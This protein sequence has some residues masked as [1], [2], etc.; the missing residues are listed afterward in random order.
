MNALKKVEY[1]FDVYSSEK[2][3]DVFIDNDNSNSVYGS[4]ILALALDSENYTTCNINKV[5]QMLLLSK[6]NRENLMLMDK[7]NHIKE[8]LEEYDKNETIDS[9]FANF[10]ST[11]ES[12]IRDFYIKESNPN[13]IKMILAKT[14]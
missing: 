4:I 3:K 6:L 2:Q 7:N 13:S 9:T 14:R 12:N 11:L 5:I 8:L 10:C 1:I